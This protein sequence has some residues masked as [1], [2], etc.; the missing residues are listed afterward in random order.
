MDE[1]LKTYELRFKEANGVTRRLSSLEA[2]DD[3]DALRLAAM[4]RDGLDIEVVQNER[5]VGAIASQASQ[6]RDTPQ[7][8]PK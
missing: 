1:G 7:Q 5:I 2:V 6:R 4:L 3:D 8:D